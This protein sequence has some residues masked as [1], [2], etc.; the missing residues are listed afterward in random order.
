MTELNLL[1]LLDG[2]VTG[3]I[4]SVIDMLN[5]RGDDWQEIHVTK[6]QFKIQLLVTYIAK[7]NNIAGEL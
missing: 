5:K 2:D 7:K 1:L 4:Q 6:D 3:A